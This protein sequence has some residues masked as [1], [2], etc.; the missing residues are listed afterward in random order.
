MSG[1]AA[2]VVIGVL[3]GAATFGCAGGGQQSAGEQ[4]VSVVAPGELPLVPGDAVRLTFSREPDLNGEYTIDEDGSAILPLLGQRQLTDRSAAQVKVDLG[5]EFAEI[6]RNQSVQ[7]AY[8][9]R[10][11]VLGEV[12][13]PGLY[14][15]DQTLM[16]DDVIALAGGA[17]EDGNLK[18]VRLIRN[19]DEIVDGLDV[20][21]S[22][23]TS[24]ESGDQLFVPKTPWI[25]RNGAVL[26]AAC[27][28]AA[29]VIVAFT[30]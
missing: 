29:G 12:R 9:R 7:V 6:T 14:Q 30:N 4:Q 11:R 17:T 23:A 27:I 18:K 25:V 13:N 19:G 22:V 24:L 26:I 5:A 1:P 2:G 3:M 21:R 16:I 8:L 20:S 15:V 28:S 10:V